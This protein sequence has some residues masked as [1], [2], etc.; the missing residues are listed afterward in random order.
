MHTFHPTV[1]NTI[2]CRIKSSRKHRGRSKCHSRVFYSILCAEID[3]ILL[4]RYKQQLQC[5][6]AEYAR[7]RLDQFYAIAGVGS[8]VLTTLSS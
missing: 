1:F 8:H 4:D 3:R 7:R 5:V 2:N 6:I